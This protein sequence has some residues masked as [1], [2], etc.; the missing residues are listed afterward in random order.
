M[1]SESFI[2]IC[3]ALHMMWVTLVSLA[4]PPA[5]IFPLHWLN[6]QMQACW[7]VIQCLQCRRRA[8][9]SFNPPHSPLE[10]AIELEAQI[11][12]EGSGENSMESLEKDG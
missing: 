11:W 2:V 3:V 5:E 7:N 1:G 4:T 10:T 9:L 12:R 8:P 6:G